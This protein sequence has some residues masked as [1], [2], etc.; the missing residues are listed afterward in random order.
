MSQL[1]QDSRPGAFTSP[2]G[3]DGLSLS[4]FDGS[5]GVSELFEY[6]VE[7]L[8]VSDNLDFDNALGHNCSVTFKTSNGPDRY[9]N[10]VMVEAQGVGPLQ[11]LFV[12]HLVLRPWLWILSR[13]SDCRI[14]HNKTAPQIISEVFR[15]RGFTDFKLSLTKR[16]PEIEYCVQYREDD[17]SFVCRLMEK[18]GIYFFFLHSQDKHLL[19]LADSKSSHEAIP[20]H[21]AT[22]Y[23]G[24]VQSRRDQE[25]F[26]RWTKERRFRSG[27]YEL[28]DYDFKC[29]TKIL[30]SDK[31]A[32][33]K[34]RHGRMEIYDYPGLYTKQRDGDDFAKVRLDADQA[35]DKR[36]YASGN[37]IS[38]YPG[39]LTT[40]ERHSVSSENIEYLV[41]RAS[42]SY[43]LQSYRSGGAGEDDYSG[44]YELLDAAI[45]YRAPLATPKALIH[46]P[47]TAR[48][49]G[50]EGEEIDVD[51]YGRILVR[52]HWDRK[53]M[54]SC[55]VRVAQVWAGKNWGG[56]II[57]RIGMEAVVEFL[58][59]DPDRPLV[60]G[61]VYNGDNPF[62]YTL[63]DNKTQSGLK[64]D[65]SLGH[66]GYNEFMFEDKKDSEVIGM[67][68][69]KDHQV[70]ILNSETT[71][72][73]EKFR[74]GDSPS[75]TTSLIKGSD[76]LTIEA[77]DQIVKISGHQQVTADKS[78]KL[79]C[80]ASVIEITPTEIKVTSGHIAFTA[81]KI[82]WN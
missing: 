19:V 17:F 72:I 27:K 6:R 31:L 58:E 67:H 68:A 75:R 14:W 26:N 48:V 79:T 44:A 42:H 47:Q 71:E 16:Y 54:D 78:I 35:N 1:L 3:K 59:G 76:K 36:R 11:D 21:D 33:S 52:F 49:V 60:V 38:L 32:E 51:E 82:D 40:L 43:V 41:L 62:P 4:R 65:S 74:A 69:Q 20:G 64:S 13:T 70:T 81:P 80:G 2:L 25:N 10:G 77:G 29:P 45:P 66:G 12:Y 28:N 5:E 8:S 15:D 22:P 56:Q 39:G 57:P 46:G 53:K 7:A 18:H 37:A 50:K 9:F 61:A 63:P 34:Y 55:R 30:K 23:F 24:G 73:G